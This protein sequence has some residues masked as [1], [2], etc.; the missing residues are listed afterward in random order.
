MANLWRRVAA[1]GAV[2]KSEGVGQA[3]VAQEK[4]GLLEA[5]AVPQG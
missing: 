5:G 2:V 3:A 4:R 1:E